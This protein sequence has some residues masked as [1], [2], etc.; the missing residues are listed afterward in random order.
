MRASIASGI[1]TRENTRSRSQFEA[2]ESI[3]FINEANQQVFL[4]QGDLA[5]GQDYVGTVDGVENGVNGSPGD[6]DLLFSIDLEDGD[7]G[8]NYNFTSVESE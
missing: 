5:D 3:Y 6:L 8:I 1:S 7:E 2:S 4:G